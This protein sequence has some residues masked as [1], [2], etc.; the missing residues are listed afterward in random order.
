MD[1]SMDCAP[2][3]EECLELYDQLSKLWGSAGM[4]ARK[5]LSNS[6]RILEKIPERD[7]ATEVDL[8]KGN[9]PSVKTKEDVFTYRAN[10]PEDAQNSL[11]PYVI[12]AKILLQEMWTSGL[13]WD[14]LLDQSQARRAKRWFEELGE[15]RC[16]IS[17]LF[18]ITL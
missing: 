14:D 9:L 5:W 11:A 4:H 7:K 6:E 1:D 18:E 2:G 8:D 15:F 17:L 12:R 3:D 13:D 16:Q 10:P